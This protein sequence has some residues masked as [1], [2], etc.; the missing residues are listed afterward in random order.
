MLLM[1]GKSISREAC[2]VILWYVK[3]NNKY[4]K[5]YNENKKSWLFKYWNINSLCESGMSQNVSAY[6][7]KWVENTYQFNRYFIQ[8]YNDEGHFLEV[9]VQYP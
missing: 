3:T 9:D 2:H 5:D 6:G 8:N 1:T 4:I 7:F